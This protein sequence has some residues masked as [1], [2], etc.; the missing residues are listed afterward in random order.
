MRFVL[1]NDVD[2]AVGQA[3]RAAGH[4]CWT[5]DKAGLAGADAASDDEVSVYAHEKHAVVVTHDREF[6]RRR[7]RTTYGKHVWLR[8]EQ[9]DAAA[10]V[11]AR[12]EELFVALEQ[13]DE[14]VVVVSARGVAVRP[15][16]WE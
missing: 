9:P 2:A 11:A 1:D 16:S 13:H 12:L 14:L 3:L 5:A 15:P 8:C 4:D 6:S 10:I 7:I